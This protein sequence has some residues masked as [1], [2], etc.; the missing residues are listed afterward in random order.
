MRYIH[1]T[2]QTVLRD[3]MWLILFALINIMEA[4]VVELNFVEITIYR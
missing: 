1:V 4:L 3:S 2:L